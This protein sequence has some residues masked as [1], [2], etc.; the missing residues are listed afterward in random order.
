MCCLG[1]YLEAQRPL[2][3]SGKKVCRFVVGG[4]GALR[5]FKGSCWKNQLNKGQT[6]KFPGKSMSVFG[7]DRNRTTVLLQ[8]NEAPRW[9]CHLITHPLVSIVTRRCSPASVC[10]GPDLVL[11]PRLDLPSRQFSCPC[12]SSGITGVSWFP[13]WSLSV[14]KGT[15]THSLLTAGTPFTLGYE[16]AEQTFNPSCFRDPGSIPL[17]IFQTFSKSGGVGF[18]SLVWPFLKRGWKTL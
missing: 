12:I 3:C 1:S 13:G 7:P 14:C 16:C 2:L 8:R 6:S 18:P 10:L 11:K 17:V 9:C 15:H 5:A 4:T